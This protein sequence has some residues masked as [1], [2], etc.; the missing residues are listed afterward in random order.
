MLRPIRL[1]L[2]NMFILQ[3][4][5]TVDSNEKKNVEILVHL[6]FK[7]SE[8]SSTH[9]ALNLVNPP[10]LRL[11]KKLGVTTERLNSFTS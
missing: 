7:E 10:F 1:K 4:M 5:N 9:C 8:P 3:V 2:Q 6:T 11:L